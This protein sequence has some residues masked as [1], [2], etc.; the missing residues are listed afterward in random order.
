MPIVEM[1]PIGRASR[2]AGLEHQVTSVAPLSQPH[3][4]SPAAVLFLLFY[5]SALMTSTNKRGVSTFTLSAEVSTAMSD[6]FTGGK[7]MRDK[8]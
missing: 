3:L 1:G 4:N 7:E 2:S 6:P 8:Q 5:G